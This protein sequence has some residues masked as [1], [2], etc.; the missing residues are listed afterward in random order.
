MAK[1]LL[2]KD[3][4]NIVSE[5]L[6]M[7]ENDFYN[8]YLNI[9][10]EH[11]SQNPEIIEGLKVVLSNWV[12]WYCSKV[13]SGVYVTVEHEDG[14]TETVDK[15]Q[16]WEVDDYGNRT[17]VDLSITCVPLLPEFNINRQVNRAFFDNQIKILETIQS[18]I[19]LKRNIAAFED[20]L[21]SVIK[22]TLAEYPQPAGFDLDEIKSR[23]KL[24][25]CIPYV[26][27]NLKTKIEEFKK[28]SDSDTKRDFNGKWIPKL[29]YTGLT[30][31]LFELAPRWV[32][33][34]NLGNAA[35]CEVAAKEIEKSPAKYPWKHYANGFF[36]VTPNFRSDKALTSAAIKEY[37][38]PSINLQTGE[39]CPFKA[40]EL[41]QL[42]AEKYYAWQTI[43]K[44]VS[45]FDN[46]LK[47]KT[48]SAKIPIKD[49]G[50]RVGIDQAKVKHYHNWLFK[51]KYIDNSLE[52]FEMVFSNSSISADKWKPLRWLR[53]GVRNEPHR[54]A[55]AALCYE[56]LDIS[57]SDPQAEKLSHFFV[58]EKGNKIIPNLNQGEG[59]FNKYIP[60]N[61][62]LYGS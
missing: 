15:N 43:T 42:M 37:W 20:G 17:K 47:E 13:Y 52:E 29:D 31:G 4:E 16:V 23:V 41:G 19:D 40:R 51:N 48:H 27:D 10:E 2:T 32:H 8:Y 34:P 9:V 12:V 1:R 6:S 60:S 59:K 46:L 26:L 11:H 28:H 50:L 36:E 53:K 3:F 5:T 18:S 62:I 7:P 45:H 57:R 14:T 33:I 49:F 25:S 21:P 38:L 35:I 39:F 55:L 61:K 58:D 22:E 30:D 54:T 44:D 24:L 56:L